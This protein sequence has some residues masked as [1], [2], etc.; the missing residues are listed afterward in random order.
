MLRR[1]L[2]SPH[3]RLVQNDTRTFCH[4]RT[5]LFL[6]FHI[7]THFI[8]THNKD[9]ERSWPQ[10]SNLFAVGYSRGTTCKLPDHSLR[11]ALPGR[12]LSTPFSQVTMT[13]CQCSHLSYVDQPMP[14]MEDCVLSMGDAYTINESVCTPIYDILRQPESNL[15]RTQFVQSNESFRSMFTQTTATRNDDGRPCILMEYYKEAPRRKVMRK[16]CLVTT[17]WGRPISELPKIFREFS[18][19][20]FPNYAI[21]PDCDCHVHSLPKWSREDA[22]IIAWVFRTNRPLIH[23]MRAKREMSEHRE[24]LVFGR[25]AMAYL[26]RDADNKRSEWVEKCKKPNFGRA[27]AKE[28][29][30]STRCRGTLAIEHS[31]TVQEHRKA[32]M[33]QE[34][35]ASRVWFVPCCPEAYSS[36]TSP[37][38]HGQYTGDISDGTPQGAQGT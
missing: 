38:V 19:P 37:K 24:N 33:A 34:A 17:Y 5:S 14:L 15:D 23:R 10:I 12:R 6:C 22:W 8:R 31:R 18:I 2:T 25:T 35:A 13:S 29:Y 16:V 30:V 3:R 36:L 28:F 32:L 7:W 4:G 9:Q 1:L 20:V 26:K 21:T 11:G 27:Y